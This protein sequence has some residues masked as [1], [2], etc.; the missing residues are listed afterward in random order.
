MR[1]WIKPDQLSK[2][3]LTVTDIQRAIQ[4]QN[5]LVPAGQIG[6]PPAPEGTEFTY[7]VQTS[8]RFSSA[9]EFG[10][11]VVRANPDGSQVMLRDVADI[12]LGAQNY[13]MNTRTDGRANALIQVFQLPDANG[14]E[15][16]EAVFEAMDDLAEVFPEDMAYTV[17][18]DTTL[19]VT[20]GIREIV[21][22]LFQAIG[23]VVLVVFIF[24]QSIRSTLIPTIAVPVSL[25]G[26]FAV[27][28]L[29]GFSIN[30]L[31]LLGLVL[32]IGIVVDDAIVVVEAVSTKM[33]AGMNANDATVEAMREVSGPIVATSLSLI[34]VFVPVAMMAGITGQMYQQFAITIAVSVAISS[35]NALTLSPALAVKLLRPPAQKKGLLDP[36]FAAFNRLFDIATRGFMVLVGFFTRSLTLSMCLLALIAGGTYVLFQW[37]P[38][39]FVPEEDQGYLMAAFQLPDGA[40]L[41]RTREVMTEIESVISGYDAVENTTTVAGFSMLTGTTAPN[42]GFAFIQLKEWAQR[43]APQDHARNVM[44]RLNRDF[45]INIQSA[46]AFAFGPP[47]IPGLGTGSG[48]S[49]MLQDRSGEEPAYLAEQLKNFIAAANQRPEIASANS[50]FRAGVPQVFLDIDEAKALKLGV[51]LDDVYNAIGAFLGGAYVNDFNRFGRLYKVYIQAL[52][53]YR[54]DT[55]SLRYFHVRNANGDMVPLS[56]FV[57]ASRTNRHRVHQTAL[58]CSAPLK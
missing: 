37:V 3:N 58:T 36:F 43:P 22:T 23:L 42:A 21:V 35:I 32:A 56:T 13:V 44:R 10:A 46:V 6:G 16:A 18:L 19:P 55:G 5:T 57:T 45:A 30:T 25:I 7:T 4:H 20:A 26:A 52:P 1:V 34:A 40:S 31:S 49:I 11:V 50:L 12:E 8:G 28:P 39:S 48:F 9:E 38:S 14:L 53:E 17:S 54:D 29:L 51:A 33:A 47:A 15:V 2:L 24:L 41:Q 27:F